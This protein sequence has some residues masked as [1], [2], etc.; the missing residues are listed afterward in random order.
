MTKFTYGDIVRCDSALSTST[1]P[2]KEGALYVVE[3]VAKHD[4]SIKVA[5]DWHS[6][7]RFEKVGRANIDVPDRQLREDMGPSRYHIRVAHASIGNA[8]VWKNS[9]EGHE[10]W[11]TVCDKLHGYEERFAALEERGGNGNG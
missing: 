9:E 7:N 1:G 4:K 6:V 10:Y 8:F 2:L 5:G 3:G 11:Q